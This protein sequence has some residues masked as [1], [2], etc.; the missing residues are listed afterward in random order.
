MTREQESMT[1]SDRR[2]ELIDAGFRSVCRIQDIPRMMPRKVDLD[3]RSILLCRDRDEV[4]AVDEIC[5]HK[6]LSMAYGV[7]F[8]G[9]I[10]CPHHQYVFELGTGR[11]RRRRCAPVMTYPVELF[12]EV[13]FVQA[14]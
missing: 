10:T 6:Q 1:M 12:D 4:F 14:D 3:G 2:Q 7:V 11:C 8:D 5:P 9:T 13:V